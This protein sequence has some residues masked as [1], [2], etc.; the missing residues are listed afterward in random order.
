MRILTSNGLYALIAGL[1]FVSSITAHMIC[2]FL[3]AC[4]KVS[5]VS[6]MFQKLLF[7]GLTLASGLLMR[8]G[9]SQILHTLLNYKIP[10]VTRLANADYAVSSSQNCV[11]SK[12]P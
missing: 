12:G 11:L 7:P 1:T 5:K 9:L 4:L 2:V 3:I 10:L 8:S 6:C